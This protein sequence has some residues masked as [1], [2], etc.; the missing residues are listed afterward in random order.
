LDSVRPLLDTPSTQPGTLKPNSNRLS[1]QTV[2]VVAPS[3]GARFSG[4]TSTVIALLEEHA[5][6]VEI[7]GLGRQIPD[8]LP[9]LYW[10]DILAAGWRPPAGRR[11]RIWHARRNIEMIW[12]LALSRLLRQPW[13]L[14]FT[15]AAQRKHT[16]F[17]KALIRR[18]DAVIATSPEAASY[19]DVPA[20]ISLHGVDVNRWRPAEDRAEAWAATGLPGRYGIG[21]FGRVRHQKGTDL[22]VHALIATLPAQPDWTAVVIGLIKPDDAAFVEGLKAKLAAAGLQDRVLFM[23]EQEFSTI[24]QWFRALSLVVAPA[25]WEGFGLVPLEAMASATPVIASRVGAHAHLVDHGRTGWLIPPDDVPALAEALQTAMALDPAARNAIG[26]VGRS[27]VEER[28]S[29]DQE[30]RRIESVYSR[31]WSEL[32]PL[33]SAK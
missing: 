17:T 30:A 8:N 24:P 12:G 15:S 28:F 3:L 22:F 27:H 19:L 9:R 21:I 5:A 7:G 20:S 29:I 33:K 6:R 11:F 32:E 16:A 1:F 10:R 26:A 2:E 4:V 31:L 23:G 14:V 18:M 25:R 13:R